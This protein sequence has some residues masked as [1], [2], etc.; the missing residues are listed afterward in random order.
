MEERRKEKLE[1]KHKILINLFLIESKK[2]VILVYIVKNSN[3]NHL[4][5]VKTFSVVI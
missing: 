5:I 4:K 2:R 1:E 3:L